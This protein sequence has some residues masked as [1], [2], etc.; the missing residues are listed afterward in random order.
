MTTKRQPILVLQFQKDLNKLERLL[1]RIARGD[2]SVDPNTLVYGYK[3]TDRN[4]RPAVFAEGFS[5]KTKGR[6]IVGRTYVERDADKSPWIK[7]SNGLNVATRAWCRRD[8][9]SSFYAEGTRRMLLV[10]FRL[11][12]VAVVPH[13]SNGKFRCFRIHVERELDSTASFPKRGR[14]AR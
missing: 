6:Y 14:A 1:K 3:Y 2:R 8:C 5:P 12:D 10:S 11:K 13:Y 4:A 9:P 7:C